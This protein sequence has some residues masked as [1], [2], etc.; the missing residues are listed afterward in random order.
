M[1]YPVILVDG[2]KIRDGYVSNRTVYVAMGITLAGERDILG[3]WVGPTGGES[4]KYWIGPLTD[5]RNRGVADVLLCCDGLKGLPD[6]AR[7][8]C[9]QVEV[10][11]CVVR[12]R[13]ASPPR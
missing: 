7:A 8:V 9:E 3:L 5:L 10:Q 6:A 12:L 2:I 13:S 4:A 1:I 11:L